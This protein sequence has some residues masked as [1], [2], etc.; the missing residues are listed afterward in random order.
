MF[1]VACW[2]DVKKNKSR[3]EFTSYTGRLL[4]KILISPSK[5]PDTTTSPWDSLAPAPD[6]SLHL[7]SASSKKAGTG[8]N[9]EQVTTALWALMAS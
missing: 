8:A 6:T 3:T 5:S 1:S 7:V 4:I 2:W 9:R